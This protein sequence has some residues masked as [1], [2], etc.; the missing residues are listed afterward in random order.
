MDFEQ[1]YN[2][3][4]FSVGLSNSEGKLL[5]GIRQKK[6]FNQFKKMLASALRVELDVEKIDKIEFGEMSK[7]D[8]S[9]QIKVT[10]QDN[11][12]EEQTEDFCLESIAIY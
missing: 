12:K 11:D 2:K 7:H 4:T 3:D 10:Y 6:N 8:Y 1:Y 9:T 5:C